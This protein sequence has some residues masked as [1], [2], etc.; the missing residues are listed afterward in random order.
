MTITI[1]KWLL[2][3]LAIALVLAL[4]AYWIGE[5]VWVMAQISGSVVR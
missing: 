2:I 4:P 1:P 5:Y 3:L